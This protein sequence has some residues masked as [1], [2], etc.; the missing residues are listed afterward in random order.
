VIR[1]WFAARS[2]ISR[3]RLPRLSLP[4][5][6]DCDRRRYRD[7]SAKDSAGSRLSRGADRLDSCGFRRRVNPPNPSSPAQETRPE[8][9]VHVSVNRWRGARMRGRR[10]PKRREL[11][12][13]RLGGSV[14]AFVGSQRSVPRSASS[15]PHRRRSQP[16][17]PPR[18]LPPRMKPRPRRYFRF[19]H[20]GV[21][22]HLLHLPRRVRS[23]HRPPRAS[24][25]SALKN[26]PSSG[27][28]PTNARSSAR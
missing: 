20:H 3:G 4:A 16:S 22:P 23:E 9:K 24:G 14:K 5:L 10:F 21:R 7:H 2:R 28:G 18:L 27:T 11:F 19:R 13:A 15:R 26:H 17:W 12:P 1:S 6:Q 8:L 25:R